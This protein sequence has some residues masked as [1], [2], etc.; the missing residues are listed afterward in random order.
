MN[1]TEMCNYALTLIGEATITD[2]DDPQDEQGRLISLLYDQVLYEVL[3]GKDF[4]CAK[5]RTTLAAD[6]TDPAFGWETRY[7]L[8]DDWLR[9]AEDRHFYENN[10][11]VIEYALTVNDNNETA[12]DDWVIENNYI[13]TNNCDND[14]ELQ[15]VYIKKMNNPSDTGKLKPHVVKLLAYELG[16]RIIQK[17]SQNIKLIQLHQAKLEQVRLWA[18]GQEARNCYRQQAVNTWVQSNR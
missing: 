12:L 2:V 1:K 5:R 3:M 7:E 9:M 15:M 18:W 16:D 14:E 8:P 10:E 11:L 4:E 13:L 17:R 6:S